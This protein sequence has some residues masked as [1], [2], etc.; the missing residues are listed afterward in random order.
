MLDD[1]FESLKKFDWGTDLA[2]LAPIDD[3][4]VGAPA[5]EQANRELENRL[6]RALK[7][8]LSRDAHDYVCRKL[9]IIGT[10]ASVPTLAALLGTKA[11][12]HMARYVLE[13][14]AAPE[15]GHALRGALGSANGNLKIG[16]IGSL[17]ARRDTASVPALGSLLHDDDPAVA[18]AAALSLGAI[19]TAESAAVLRGA[20]QAGVGDKQATIDALLHCAESLLSGEKQADALLIYQSLNSEPNGRLVRLAATRGL[21][22]CASK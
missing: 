13:R 3:A 7:G 14:M 5:E 19:G 1:A 22:A 15:A 8:N 18:R 10:A 2:I 20:L 16:V 9:T 17:G 11:T 12:S 21:L 4:T 6:L